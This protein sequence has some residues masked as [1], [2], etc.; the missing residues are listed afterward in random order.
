MTTMTMTKH[1]IDQG[2]MMMSQDDDNNNNNAHTITATEV[3]EM[4][5][6][7]SDPLQ[8]EP[9]QDWNNGNQSG[10]N[11]ISSSSSIFSN[12]NKNNNDTNHDPINHHHHHHY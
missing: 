8:E 4:S 2:D 12:N 9:E 10:Y 11:L 3:T 1:K 7:L 6:T 5:T